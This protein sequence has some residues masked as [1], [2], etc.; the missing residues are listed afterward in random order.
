MNFTLFAVGL[1]KIVF[2]GLVAA[3]GIWLAFRGLNRLL[4]TNAVEDLR[5]G[6]TAAG[7]LHASSLLALGL[8]VQHSVQATSDAADLILRSPP[9]QL[10][11]VGK[12]ALFALLHVVLSL[13]VGTG[14]L[15][16]GVLLFDRMTPGLDELDEVRKGNVSLALVL[17]AI[18]LVLALL[19]APGL[20]AALNGLIPFPKLPDAMLHAPA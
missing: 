14:V 1:I 10:A 16:L 18:L 11:M 12:V 5:K 4:R 2:G 6:N 3:L 13:A 19:T 8:L 17:S 20:Q 7:I 9:F 15:A